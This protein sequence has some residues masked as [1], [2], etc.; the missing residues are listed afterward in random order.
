MSTQSPFTRRGPAP[1]PVLPRGE[2]LATY[3]TYAE[4]QAAVDSLAKTEFP[5]KE[6]AIVG[7]DLKSVERVTGKLRWGRVALTGAGSG[8]WLGV[9][10]GLLFFVFTPTGSSL[11]F[12]LA[13]VLIGAGLGMLFG[14]V[15]YSISRRR[16]DYTSTMQVI[17]SNYQ[18]VVDAALVNRARNLLTG[19]GDRAPAPAP[20]ATG[21][22]TPTPVEPPAD[23]R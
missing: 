18:V 19:Q 23:A 6:L 17:A 1:S 10:F 9:F 12:V 4:A 20:E 14:I 7:N 11:P 13:A 2:V 8:A 22:G 16:R 5:V 3:D 15:T 21:A